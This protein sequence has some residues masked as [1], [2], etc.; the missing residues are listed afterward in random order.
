MQRARG[1]VR[2]RLSPIP[3]SKPRLAWSRLGLIPYLGG[4]GPRQ[5]HSG[6]RRSS[7]EPSSRPGGGVPT[8][9]GRDQVAWGGT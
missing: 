1:P 3:H 4:L 6:P 8:L 9:K 7:R 2:W 5:R